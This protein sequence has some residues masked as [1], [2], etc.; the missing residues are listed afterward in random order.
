MKRAF[1]IAIL[2]V[3]TVTALIFIGANDTQS[4]AQTE[5]DAAEIYDTYVNAEYLRINIGR[6]TSDSGVTGDLSP[7]ELQ[8]QIDAYNEK[9]DRYFSTES[10][11]HQ[12]YKD[13][14]EK[15][16]RETFRDSAN[17]QLDAGVYDYKV[18]NLT[19]YE[20]GTAVL[21][22]DAV[23]YN[24]WVQELDDG[25][26]IV[27]CNA[28]EVTDTCRFV[29]EDGNWK[30]LY[31]EYYEILSDWTPLDDA[32]GVTTQALQG[33]ETDSPVLEAA[34]IETEVYSDFDEAKSACE[35]ISMEEIC[36]YHLD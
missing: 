35:Q 27:I 12:E 30:Y 28:E 25:S 19:I 31:S 22:T 11:F 13:L 26:Y 3:F 17:Y 5:R 32:E 7:E 2:A 1:S 33:D 34:N 18:N 20:D 14:N 15:Y 24:K 9:I 21:S 23:L 8:A 4:S 16:L 36:P 6:Y 29:K 10:R